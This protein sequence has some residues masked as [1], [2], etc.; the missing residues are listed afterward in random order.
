[1]IKELGLV[2]QDEVDE[3][4]SLEHQ[5]CVLK[6]DVYS[7]HRTEET[8]TWIK[9]TYPW[10]LLIFVPA[11]CT[12]KLQE[13]DVRVNAQLQA[14]AKTKCNELQVARLLGELE[15][16]AAAVPTISLTHTQLKRDVFP[17]LAA[18]LTQARA[19]GTDRLR[20]IWRETG[21]DRAWDSFH[22]AIS[23]RRSRAYAAMTQG[24]R[25]D[26]ARSPHDESARTRRPG[27]R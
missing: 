18:G 16:D 15:K 3:D 6:W 23:S 13:L 10:L 14:G 5:R 1:M 26:S 22:D 24:A 4:S 11:S 25:K 17:L 19:L 7:V 20:A 27:T 21:C 8:R 12:S 9:D 2:G